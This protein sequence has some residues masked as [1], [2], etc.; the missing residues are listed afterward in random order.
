MKLEEFEAHAGNVTCV[1]LS[2]ASYRIIAS[3]GNDKRCNVWRIGRPKSLYSF[4]NHSTEVACL[5]FHRSE[6]RIASGSMGGSI[7][8]YDLKHGKLARNLKGHMN[9]VTTIDYHPFGEFLVSSSQ[10]SSVK[11]WDLR[12][13]ACIQNYKRY[14]EGDITHVKFSPDGSWVASS[15]RKGVVNIHDLRV[16]KLCSKIECGPAPIEAFLF[17]PSEFLMAVWSEDRNVRFYECNNFSQVGRNYIECSGGHVERIVFRRDGE[18]IFIASSSTL[19][20][21]SKGLWDNTS[22][23]DSKISGNRGSSEY[24]EK[25]Y[26]TEWK[27]KIRDMVCSDDNSTIVSASFQSSLVSVYAVDV[28]DEDVDNSEITYE[29]AKGIDAVMSKSGRHRSIAIGDVESD[30]EDVEARRCGGSSEPKTDRRTRIEPD[31]KY[32]S[33]LQ[34]RLIRLGLLIKRWNRGD[35]GGTIRELKE[36][37]RDPQEDRIVAWNFLDGLSFKK[38]HLNLED[39]LAFIHLLQEVFTDSTPYIACVFLK[40]HCEMLEMYGQYVKETLSL[41]QSGRNP[42]HSEMDLNREDRLGRCIRFDKAVKDFTIAFHSVLSRHS[43]VF[44][45]ED[46]DDQ[47]RDDQDRDDR[48]IELECDLQ[49]RLDKYFS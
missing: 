29:G 2:P 44:D 49:H 39:S 9:A 31:E 10:D 13:R 30:D 36:I 23:E 28:S 7:R 32:F 15:D 47:D 48:L 25:T 21:F 35:M 20:Y 5:K 14:H 34:S 4:G 22:E 45:G 46:R 1:E 8:V 33:L 42:F 3:G 17:N 24:I 6:E 41:E 26:A 12:E 11:L 38:N 37:C 16:N 19:K 40:K 18:G 43:R 27:H